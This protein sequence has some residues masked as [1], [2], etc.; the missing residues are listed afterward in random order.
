MLRRTSKIYWMAH[1]NRKTCC[2]LSLI[3]SVHS[4]TCLLENVCKFLF[5]CNAYSFVSSGSMAVGIR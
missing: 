1:V 4:K 3:K 2:L 5:H